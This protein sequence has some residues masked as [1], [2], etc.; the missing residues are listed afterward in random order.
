M[1]RDGKM[2]VEYK[3][4]KFTDYSVELVL[5]LFFATLFIAGSLYAN[6]PWLPF[7]IIVPIVICYLNAVFT[8]KNI[9]DRQLNP[10]WFWKYHI[11]FG[12]HVHI[13]KDCS[14]FHYTD[15][16]LEFLLNLNN[17]FSHFCYNNET[18]IVFAKK[19]DAVEFLLRCS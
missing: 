6:L 5:I 16:Q 4:W 12:Y 13:K 15:E 11:W 9:K 1:Q 18:I 17:R 3:G 10:D 14:L 7:M 2:K 19:K 8:E